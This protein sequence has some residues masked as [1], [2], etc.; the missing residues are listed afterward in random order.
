MSITEGNNEL[1]KDFFVKEQAGYYNSFIQLGR[2]GN[3][4]IKKYSYVN[5]VKDTIASLHPSTVEHIMKLVSER[6]NKNDIDAHAYPQLSPPS[7]YSL[8]QKCNAS[9]E[10]INSRFVKLMARMQLLCKDANIEKIA[11]NAHSYNA[12]METCKLESLEIATELTKYLLDIQSYIEEL[13]KVWEKCGHDKYNKELVDLYNKYQNSVDILSKRFNL[14]LDNL[15]KVF[16]NFTPEMYSDKNEILFFISELK[17][18]TPIT[19]PD[20]FCYKALEM[21]KALFSQLVAN[22]CLIFDNLI[23]SVKDT[24]TDTDTDTDKITYLM[25]L[26][27]QL[28]GDNAR[29]EL[30]SASALRKKLS[31]AAARDSERKAKEYAEQVRKAEHMQKAMGCLGKVLGWVVTAVGVVAA[32]FTGGASLALAGVGLGLVVGDEIYHAVTG[33][34]FIQDGL[35]LVMKPLMEFMSKS[36]SK[37]LSDFGIKGKIKELVGNIMGAIAASLIFIAG[38]AVAGS[39]IGKVGCA[40]FQNVGASLAKKFAESELSALLARQLSKFIPN[41]IGDIFKKL[42]GGIGRA[43]GFSEEKLAQITTYSQMSEGI[44]STFNSGIQAAGEIVVNLNLVDA[45]KAK[46]ELQK[47][48]AIQDVIKEM[49]DIAI[50]YYRKQ[51]V[52]MNSIIENMSAIAENKYHANNFIVGSI[53]STFA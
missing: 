2:F 9:D 8:K 24:D 26:I 20:F 31:E 34:S 53:N 13:S 40:V 32:A 22:A 17:E 37:L 47:N 46:S 43:F 6:Q 10:T 51:L 36:F 15:W 49:F 12:L 1:L 5:K 21:I 4:N 25:A 16:G 18:T 23:Q 41:I 39:V 52:S 7:N 42:C 33:H 44:L 19:S 35:Q 29:D 27:A 50:E 45:E 3:S 14:F 28:V 38:L 30:E 11:M 48:I